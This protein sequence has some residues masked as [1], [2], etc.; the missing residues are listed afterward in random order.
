MKRHKI[1]DKNGVVHYALPEARRQRLRFPD[2]QYTPK[3]VRYDKQFKEGLC[4]TCVPGKWLQ[5]KNSAFWYHKQF[6]HG[7]S[8][9]TG[10]QFTEPVETRWLDQELLEGLCH[11][12]KK[13][14]PVN[15]MRRQGSVVWYR[16]AHK[17]TLCRDV[18]KC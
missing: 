2:D 3:W 13:W 16:H 9:V 8:S 18:F 6:F 7:I 10:K 15:N 17:V 1:I 12:C 4:D 5:L 14:V 11:Q